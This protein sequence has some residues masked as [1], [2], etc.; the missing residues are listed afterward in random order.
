[1]TDFA[2]SLNYAC[3]ARSLLV[4][5][6]QKEKSAAI[7]F[8]LHIIEAE[9]PFLPKFKAQILEAT[10]RTAGRL[11]QPPLVYSSARAIARAT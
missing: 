8:S 1:V 10:N 2:P 5:P 9:A 3:M 7:S 4:F 11:Q 6:R